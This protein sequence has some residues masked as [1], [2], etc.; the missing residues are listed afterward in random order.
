M[1]LE[2]VI[3]LTYLLVAAQIKTDQSDKNDNNWFYNKVYVR[4]ILKQQTSNLNF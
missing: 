3:S 1:Q 4:I 2:A